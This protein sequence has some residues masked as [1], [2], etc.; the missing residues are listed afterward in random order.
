MN[1]EWAFLIMIIL[2]DKFKMVHC[3]EVTNQNTPNF[4]VTYI[5]YSD[6]A[7]V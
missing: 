6:T 5:C 2:H 7:D 1:F 4:F 3:F